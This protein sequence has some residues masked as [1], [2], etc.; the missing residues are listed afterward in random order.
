M[1]SPV[2]GTWILMSGPVPVERTIDHKLFS[3][4][5][6]RNMVARSHWSNFVT[7]ST[8]IG[9]SSLISMPCAMQFVRFMI[10]WA[11]SLH[12][13]ASY[14]ALR[15]SSTLS[16]AQSARAR[17]GDIAS[18]SSMSA[19]PKP[20]HRFSDSTSGRGPSGPCHSRSRSWTIAS[21]P[22]FVPC[23]DVSGWTEKVRSVRLLESI[24]SEKSSSFLVSA[25]MRSAFELLST[26]CLATV[27]TT[28]RCVSEMLW[29]VVVGS[30]VDCER[31][32]SEGLSPLTSRLT[33]QRPADAVADAASTMNTSA[34][35]AQNTSISW[36]RSPSRKS[37]NVS[38]S[39]SS[40]GS[41]EIWVCCQRRFTE[42]MAGPE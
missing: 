9:N 38:F 42:R 37:M 30:S 14:C 34:S 28:L 13:L 40:D 26:A 22:L 3:S 41:S 5:V 29:R 36:R 31:R 12:R 11:C 21:A 8:T 39:S 18:A 16:E 4:S 24:S 10:D 25:Q 23:C 35:A 17:C 6:S 19:L 32:L 33:C 1:D 2:T 7:S 27:Q 15:D 20:A